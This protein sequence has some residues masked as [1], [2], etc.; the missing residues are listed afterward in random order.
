MATNPGADPVHHPATHEFISFLLL[1]QGPAAAINITSIDG[2]GKV[3]QRVAVDPT[4]AAIESCC[5]LIERHLPQINRLVRV[6][7]DADAFILLHAD[8]L[9]QSAR[10]LATSCTEM[11]H[12]FLKIQEKGLSNN[13]A[14][15]LFEE[16]F[17]EMQNTPCFDGK[18]TSLGNFMD[19][20]KLREVV[21]VDAMLDLTNKRTPEDQAAEYLRVFRIRQAERF[22]ADHPDLSN[23]S[24]ANVNVQDLESFNDGYVTRELFGDHLKKTSWMLSRSQAELEEVL[25]YLIELCILNP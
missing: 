6:D 20:H 22:R 7:F 21:D 10:F 1:T 14:V 8:L 12:A 9:P 25:D 16:M 2:G 5:D 15:E 4:N 11:V 13:N 23:K 17:A 3:S 18:M 24:E 19:K